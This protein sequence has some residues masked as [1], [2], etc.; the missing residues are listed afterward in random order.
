[1][2]E[3][4]MFAKTII[5]SDA[6]LDMPLSSQAL[7]FHLSMRADDDGFVNNPK[8]ILRMIG[9][10][11]D[12]F[13]LLILK[14]FVIPFESGVCVIKHWFIHNY[15]RSDRY[16]ETV[17][18]DEKSRLYSK[19]N[20]AYTLNPPDNIP[21][22]PDSGIPGGIPDGNQMVDNRETQVRLGKDRD[23][24]GEDSIDYLP[25]A[26][27][28]PDLPPAP[29]SPVLISITLNDKTEFPIT[30]A[31][32]QGWKDLYPAVD[33][34]QELRKMKGWAD[35]N[36][37]KRKTKTGI[38]RFINAWLAKEQDRYRGPA[39]VGQQPYQ[40]RGNTGFQTSNPFMEMR[41]ER[42]GHE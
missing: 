13:K 5:D 17:Y 29:S 10:S 1:M 40:G 7:Y 6:F 21:P 37:T 25:E 23:R 41:N 24:L 12:D 34:M 39:E 19:E 26:E 28:A 8:K 27:T 20:K 36:P 11:E 22:L 15:I 31:D 4:R 18:K 38:K 42:M 30:E 2:A 14:K 32:I 3:R 33:V 9:A 35:A 16:K